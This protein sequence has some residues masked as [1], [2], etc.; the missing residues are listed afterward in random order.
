MPDFG[1]DTDTLLRILAALPVI[2]FAITVH[3]LSHAWVAYR[4]GDPTPKQHGRITLNPVAHF[5]PFGVFFILYTVFSG[6]GIGWG[7][8]VV[9]NPAN[10]RNP[11]RDELWV[12]AAGPISN[13]LQATAF[14]LI[15]PF[16]LLLLAVT[17]QWE[18]E[19]LLKFVQYFLIMGVSINLALAFFNL[20]PLFPLDGEKVL[21]QSLPLLQA[22]KLAQLRPY[23]MP[24]LLGLLVVGWLTEGWINPIFWWIRL[25]SAP[26]QWALNSI[27]AELTA[28]LFGW[29]L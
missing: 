1:L 12:S 3:E 10:F 22:H 5:D 29:F 23:G 18:D 8:P 26:F 15:T 19:I 27:T 25:L 20:I 16:I 21:M 4:C 2:F 9:I 17:G 28:L 6:F 24:I 7:K 14:A 13:L 11:R